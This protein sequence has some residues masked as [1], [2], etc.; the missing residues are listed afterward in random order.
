M[1]TIPVATP[2]PVTYRVIAVA[3]ALD[4]QVET[5]ESNNILVSSTTI[6]VALY[7]PDLMVTAL[8]VP[9]SGAAGRPLAITN[10]VTNAGPAPATSFSVRFYLSA[11]DVLDDSDV[12]LGARAVGGLGAGAVST[13]VTTL[14]IPAGTAVPAT[15][16]VLAVVDALG[17]QPETNEG[18]NMMAT[19][20][21][22]L[23]APYLPDLKMT[24]ISPAAGATA[25]RT[26][27]ITHTVSNTGTAPAGFFTIRFYL[28]A[29]ATLDA[30]DVLLGVR[31]LSSLGAG[32]SSPALT[33]V[34]VPAGTV[35]PNPYRILAVVDALGQQ[36]ELDESNNV[37]AS[38]PLAPGSTTSSAR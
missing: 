11:D 16:H 24:A 26:L 32:A 5:D 10:T 38:A 19:S 18:N 2:A 23:I 36:T 31:A 9:A 7:R 12:L 14:A 6:D 35:V 22:M 33:V 8:G 34:T 25:G 30:S 3:D 4:Q 27:A 1:V 15:Y 20:S 37:L 28:S 17:Q 13:A 21:P 29:D